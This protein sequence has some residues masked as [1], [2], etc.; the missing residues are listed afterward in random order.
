MLRNK[1]NKILSCLM[2]ISILLG[3]TNFT[4]EAKELTTVEEMK[5]YLIDIG[6]EPD[7]LN[8]MSE[9]RIENLYS[10][11]IGKEVN[12]IDYDTEI[13]DIIE[14]NPRQKGQISTSKLE[15][16]IGVYEVKE[17]GIIYEMIVSTG[18]RWLSSPLLKM[19]D[20][21]TFTFDGEKFKC[22]GIY[23]ESGY[24]LSIDQWYAVDSVDAPAT[25]ADGGLGWYLKTALPSPFS[26]KSF[27]Y[28][29]GEF[30]LLPRDEG[31]TYAQLSSSMYYT[32]AHQIVGHSISLTNEH[33][34]VSIASGS[35]D[36]QTKIYNY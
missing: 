27:N 25:A 6:S 19:T 30:Y 11:C 3:M 33:G 35:Y 5:A 8:L 16:S 15:L 10:R 34:T 22:E 13:F 7:L 31:A 21:H 1:T 9:D 29:G 24:T 20:A 23:A 26:A 2:I 18:Y 14:G 32:Y 28:G 4:V 36:Y 12:F 17:D